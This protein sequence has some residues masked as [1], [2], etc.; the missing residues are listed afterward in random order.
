MDN[1]NKFGPKTSSH[2][3]IGKECPAC[4]TPFK[5]GDYTTLISLGPGKDPE[6]QERC[7]QG[8]PYNAI[9]VEVHYSCATGVL[10]E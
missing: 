5:E 4:H 8:R 1:L 2:P 7:R 3:S 9:A 6:A 10:E